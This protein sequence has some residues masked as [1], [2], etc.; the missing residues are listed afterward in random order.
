MQNVE[1]QFR[2]GTH[3]GGRRS[4]GAVLK[5]N[6]KRKT[7]NSVLEDPYLSALSDITL[8]FS[9]GEIVGLVGHN[10]S[11]KST[12]LKLI[13][14]VMAPSKGTCKTRGTTG[15][16]LEVGAGFY[17]ELTGRENIYIVGNILGMHQKS[18]EYQFNNIVDFAELDQRLLDTPVKRYSSGQ[19]MRLAFSISAHLDAD[20]LLVDEILAVGDQKF[21]EKCL[22]K[23]RLLSESGKTVIFVSHQLFLV[24][25]IC[26]RVIWLDRGRVKLDG[27]T[28]D[29]LP[30]YRES[31]VTSGTTDLLKSAAPIFFNE[32]GQ[33]TILYNCG[34][35]IYVECNVRVSEK[36]SEENLFFCIWKLGTWQGDQLV[37]SVLAKAPKKQGTLKLEYPGVLASGTYK[38]T[39]STSTD[40]QMSSADSQ[41]GVVHIRSSSDLINQVNQ[42]TTIWGLGTTMLVE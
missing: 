21:Q 42:N 30:I 27:P 18:I 5:D 6:I 34:E 24:A 9:E 39:L 32:S 20:I 1:K 15:S 31:M 17:M 23:M 38:F 14:R 35:P 10:G 22:N 16:L 26:S 40:I 19:Y 13:N 29:V 11:G 28:E 3:V 25:D 7:M 8:D 36:H 2:M 37:A 4:L 33:K 41:G 12:L